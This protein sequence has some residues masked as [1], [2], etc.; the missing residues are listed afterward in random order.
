MQFARGESD[1][2]PLWMAVLA[3]AAQF[4]MHPARALDETNALWWERWLWG[5]KVKAARAAVEHGKVA[6]DWTKDLSERER[7]LIYWAETHED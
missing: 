6:T 3:F 5:E 1:N 7:A 2:T 4:G